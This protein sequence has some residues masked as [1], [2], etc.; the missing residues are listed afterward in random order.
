VLTPIFVVLVII[1]TVFTS[2]STRAF[3]D[4]QRVH[5]EGRQIP[6]AV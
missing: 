1:A 5:R 6:P 4:A 3:L 2:P